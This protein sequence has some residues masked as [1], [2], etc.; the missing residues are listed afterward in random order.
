MCCGECVLPAPTPMIVMFKPQ[1][2]NAIPGRGI[3]CSID[4]NHGGLVLRKQLEILLFTETI[5]NGGPTVC[6]W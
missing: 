4:I 1:Q 5:R 3:V 2:S 6:I